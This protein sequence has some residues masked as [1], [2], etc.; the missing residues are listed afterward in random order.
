[1]AWTLHRLSFAEELAPIF[2]FVPNIL[3]QMK[4]W[5]SLLILCLCV[6]WG[7]TGCQY[8]IKRQKE[9]LARKILEN[10]RDSL[11]RIDTSLRQDTV[12]YKTLETKVAKDKRH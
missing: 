8:S 3:I 6:G 4:Q 12:F 2:A 11:G 10:A 5:I 1:M 9:K 7:L